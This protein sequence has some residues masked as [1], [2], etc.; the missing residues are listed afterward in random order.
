MQNKYLASLFFG[1]LIL[2][3]G[4]GS[5]D[6][7]GVTLN[8]DFATSALNSVL[9]PNLRALVAECPVAASND[10]PGFNANL[11]CDGDGGVIAYQTP[12]SYT[13]VLKSLYF[14][15]ADSSKAYLLNFNSLNDINETGIIKFTSASSSAK[16]N[17]PSD[18][19]T[20]FVPTAVGFEV[21]YFELTIILY[22]KKTTLR[23]YMSDDDFANQGGGGHHQGDITY[24]DDDGTEHWA[25]G[26]FN[27]LS[28]PA[29]TLNRGDFA[30]G[31]GGTDGE[32]GHTRGMFGSAEFWNATGLNMGAQADIY[33]VKFDLTTGT[34][35]A[36]I[37]FDIANTWFY[38]N[39][40][41]DSA[42]FD[43]CTT[44]E[45]CAAG[46][47]WAALFP[48]ITAAN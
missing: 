48:S 26:G 47:A 23:I 14:A 31:D 44:D 32:T 2:N 1:F 29:E 19:D 16:V 21:Y 24:L 28:S 35:A 18:F 37:N 5:S 45:A 22:G 17:L 34:L 11:D 30:N 15:S 6:S 46:S 20:A 13:L 38:E 12:E 8:V 9:N 33:F 25:R 42:S 10:E 40:D 27:W 3:S 36:T 7:T 41:S 43:P 39:F 4:C